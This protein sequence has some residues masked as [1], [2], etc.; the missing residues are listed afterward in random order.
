MQIRVMRS[1]ISR[2]TA[3]TLLGAFSFALVLAVAPQWHE[4][5]HLDSG[6]PGHQCAVTLIASGK[7]QQGTWSS[8]S[9]GPILQPAFGAVPILNS[10]WVPAVFSVA[11]IFEHAP[12]VFS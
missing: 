12:P 1:S 2:A 11:A 4:R 10:S 9:A 6:R 5:L 3:I 8:A 7:F